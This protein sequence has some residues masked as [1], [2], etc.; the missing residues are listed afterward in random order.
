[1]SFGLPANNISQKLFQLTM[2][3]CNKPYEDNNFVPAPCCTNDL[4]LQQYY[5]KTPRNLWNTATNYQGGPAF[6]RC[7]DN[8]LFRQAMLSQYYTYL[9]GNN[10]LQ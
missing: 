1:M 9:S 6:S 5:K 10:S 3:N 2:P 7:T 4:R 8:A